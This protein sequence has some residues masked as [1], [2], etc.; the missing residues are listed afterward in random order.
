MIR[1]A[2]TMGDPAGIGPEIVL[3]A[4]PDYRRLGEVTIYGNDAV[5]RTTARA[6]GLMAQYRAIKDRIADRGGSARFRFG[7]PD[8]ASACSAMA[9][10]DAALAADPD[11]IVTAPIVK[12][13]VQRFIPGFV[14][15]T[16]YLARH[17]RVRNYAMVGL[18][19]ACRIMVLTT[20]LPLRHVFRAIT[21]QA[22]RDHL[23]VFER[24]L[25]RFFG[26]ARPR[27]GVAG[28][29]P[30]GWEFTAGEEARIAR[31]IAA[32]RRRGIQAEGPFPA[33]SLYARD[34][35]GFLAMYHDQAFVLLKSRPG[36]ANWT[37]GLPVVRLSPLYGAALDIAGQ[38][39]ADAAGMISSLQLGTELHVRGANYCSPSGR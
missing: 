27:I 35:D 36:G 32:A 11:V 14:G 10:L 15:H 22:V 1:I 9:A 39:R 16:E 33:D 7:V 23:N 13:T 8:R 21:P 26:I 37:L 31:G 6:L 18:L 2:V 12:R 38:G 4:L 3:K 30:H 34:Y 5:F 17:Y 25:R 24:G 28:V 19:G 29:N 20:H